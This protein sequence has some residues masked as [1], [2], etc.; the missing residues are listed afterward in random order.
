M[1]LK[2]ANIPW[3][4]AQFTK[5]IEKKTISFDNII[6]RSYVWEQSRKSKLVDSILQGYP[7]PSV[8][9][10]KGENGVYDI[11]D[12][13]QRLSALSDFVTDRYSLIG[14][15][16]LCLG[17]EPL[18]DSIDYSDDELADFD[19]YDS[20]IGLI[21]LDGKIYID[22]NKKKFSE[23]P[24]Y[25]RNTISNFRLSVYYFEDLTDEEEREMFKR[26]NSGKPLT[27]KERNIANCTDI[28][29]IMDLAKSELIQKMYTKKGLERKNYVSVIMKIWC[30]CY[31]DINTISFESKLF[32]KIITDMK[33]DDEE[34]EELARLFDEISDVHNALIVRK[35]K[36]TARKLYT[37]T[38][39]VSAAPF[40]LDAMK[41]EIEV[42]V[43]ADWIQSFFGND[44][45]TSNSDLYNASC[46]AGSARS[47][48]IRNRNKELE[49]S[50][51]NFFSDYEAESS[52]AE[53][54]AESNDAFIN[55]PVE[56]TSIFPQNEMGDDAP[57]P[58]E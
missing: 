38:H 35:D 23:L 47:D 22:L 11:L 53:A 50:Y 15:D 26:L 10:K 3:K 49:E 37:E 13:K 40:I 20:E 16:L 34:K 54:E 27:V 33:I 55:E 30:M 58:E 41:K 56:A 2:R 46:K 57:L 28:H 43:T 25:I 4:V 8:Y 14:L 9:S 17:E 48:A 5:M 21:H 39:L 51:E 44:T 24:L 42:P 12:G 29:N 1:S 7:I 45:E 36:K 19:R 31:N 18:S 52:K 6:Q 32:N